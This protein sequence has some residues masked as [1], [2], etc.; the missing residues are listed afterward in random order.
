[1]NL[2]RKPKDKREHVPNWPTQIETLL[3]TES[4]DTDR[5]Y[6]MREHVHQ[7]YELLFNFSAV[8]LRHTVAGMAHDTD[9][10][11]ILF[12][13]PYILH[14]TNARDRQPY[15]RTNIGFHPCVLTEY[16]GICT[17][18][19]LAN[20]WECVIPTTDEQMA[21]LEPL[22]VRLRRVRDPDVPKSV[23]LGTLATLLWEVNQLAEAAIR[24]DREAPPYIQDLLRYVVEHADETIT[25]DS[26]AERFFIS[27][28][29]LTRDFRAAV[30]MS[31]H[32]YITAIRLHRAKILLA[33]K[34]PLSLIAE[35]CGF[36][37][38]SA[39]IYTFRRHIGTTP[40]EYRRQRQESR[41]Q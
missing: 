23:W 16:G 3:M 33:E 29:K 4:T 18:G 28:A 8:P 24:H 20:C 5:G 15:T 39:F 35:R 21:A 30:R 9:T 7:Y 2:E 32:E 17:L 14:A 36:G 27:R 10:P 34:I 41:I 38:E 19:R 40:G 25:I 11:F 22:L 31:L 37:S 13:A 26:L 6:K 12:R 1:M